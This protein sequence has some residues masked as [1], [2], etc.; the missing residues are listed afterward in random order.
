MESIEKIGPFTNSV[1]RNVI[2]ECNKDE[3]QE[4]IKYKIIDPLISHI[5]E[6]I[7]PYVIAT[8]CTFILLF[9]L[10]TWILIMIIKTNSYDIKYKV[11]I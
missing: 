9:I 1:I 8:I 2:D 10:I 3:T 4:R 7:Q 11:T 5:A 6:K